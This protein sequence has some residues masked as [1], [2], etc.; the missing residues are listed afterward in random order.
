MGER[1]WE[2]GVGGAGIGGTC[3]EIHRSGALL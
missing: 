2:G 1:W 3:D